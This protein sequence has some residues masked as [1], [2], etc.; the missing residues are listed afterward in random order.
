MTTARRHPGEPP[1]RHRGVCV[2]ALFNAAKDTMVSRRQF[3]AED[4]GFEPRRCACF[5]AE[6]PGHHSLSN[7]ARRVGQN[8]AA[9]FNANRAPV[10]PIGDQE[11][12]SRGRRPLTTPR[13]AGHRS[14]N[15]GCA[16][17]SSHSDPGVTARS[18]GPCPHK[19]DFSL[20]VHAS[21]SLAWAWEQVGKHRPG[22][23]Q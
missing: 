3:T 1:R 7:H 13:L 18:P 9:T 2:V 22:D 12:F 11:R 19:R 6:Q 17:G 23:S 14:M 16:R 4:H 10:S 5:N 8:A 15:T 21:Q 20:G